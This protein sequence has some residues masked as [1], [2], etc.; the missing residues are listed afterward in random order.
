MFRNL[1]NNIKV[2]IIVFTI[3][4]A[5]IVGYFISIGL[6][7]AGMAISLFIIIK[8]LFT[9]LDKRTNTDKLE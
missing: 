3:I 7:V 6:V 4:I 8:V 5:T 2:A 9:Q 1:L